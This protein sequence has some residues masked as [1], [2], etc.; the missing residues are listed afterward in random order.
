MIFAIPCLKA[1][2]ID[3]QGYEVPTSRDAKN[4]QGLRNQMKEWIP[5]HLGGCKERTFAGMTIEVSS[6]C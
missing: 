1:E 3:K 5:V 6:N 2:A 4:A